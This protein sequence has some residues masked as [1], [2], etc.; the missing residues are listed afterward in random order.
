LYFAADPKVYVNGITALVPPT[1][2][3]RIRGL[4]GQLG[5]TLWKWTLGR[6]ASMA[7]IAVGASLGLWL[8]GIPLPITLGVLAGLLTFVPNIG[9]FLG[10][11]LPS[12]LAFQEGPWT[13]VWVL[14]FFA[15]LQV[16]ESNVF[17]PLVQQHQVD[18]PPGLLLSAQLLMG[19]LA[20]ILGVAMATPIAAILLVIVRE[21]YVVDMLEHGSD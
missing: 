5:D 4:L 7:V 17:T 8:L 18:V 2:R 12:L 19:A 13:V 6:L 20:G 3:T 15:L 21:L 10:V 14:V 11:V 1:R 16:L 9:G